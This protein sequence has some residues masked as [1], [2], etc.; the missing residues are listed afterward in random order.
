MPDTQTRDTPSELS[1][2]ITDIVREDARIRTYWNLHKDC[3]SIVH[4][5]GD[6]YGRVAG[7][8]R[9][10]FLL[11]NVE[12]R[13]QEATRQRII[14][15]G[16]RDICAYVVGRVESLGSVTPKHIQRMQNRGRPVQFNPFTSDSFVDEEGNPVEQATNLLCSVNFDS[17]TPI[18]QSIPDCYYEPISR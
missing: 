13:V 1:L 12:F 4:A 7:Y 18:I 15:D 3:Y 10:P 11:K 9:M 5:E 8:L 14:E 2:S 16:V 6:N 17:M